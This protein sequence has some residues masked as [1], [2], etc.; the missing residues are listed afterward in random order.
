MELRIS[1]IIK[2][3]NSFFLNLFLKLLNLFENFSIKSLKKYPANK[4]SK[5]N[6]KT[7]KSV[8]TTFQK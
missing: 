6:P 4:Y 8:L 7:I 2:K 3:I 1:L 5:D